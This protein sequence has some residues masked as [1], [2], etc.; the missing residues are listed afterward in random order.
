MARKKNE[1]PVV[2]PASYVLSG[3]SA[4]ASRTIPYPFLIVFFSKH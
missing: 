4:Q 1:L 2:G 3:Q